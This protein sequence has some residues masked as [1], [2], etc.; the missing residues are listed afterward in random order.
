METC[1]N[2]AL[3]DLVGDSMRQEL[4]SAVARQLDP[5]VT[6]FVRPELPNP[7]AV[8]VN[9]RRHLDA[10]VKRQTHSFLPCLQK[11]R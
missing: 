2:F 4:S 1:G 8:V 11:L 3:E 7:A 9:P 5:S 10:L 6:T